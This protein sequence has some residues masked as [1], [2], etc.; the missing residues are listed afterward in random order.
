MHLSGE[1]DVRGRQDYFVP[2]KKADGAVNWLVL[3][4][5]NVDALVDEDEVTLDEAGAA[6]NADSTT[7]TLCTG[8]GLLGVSRDDALRHRT[9]YGWPGADRS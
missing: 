3:A 1:V 5:A 2:T 9:V 4:D 7:R 8:C 6:A